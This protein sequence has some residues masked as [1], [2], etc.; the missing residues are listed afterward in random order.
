MTNGSHKV[1]D[2]G[3]PSQAENLSTGR[4]GMDHRPTRTPDP[5][6]TYAIHNV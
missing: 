5:T 1:Y 4:L 2:T 3:L 6:V